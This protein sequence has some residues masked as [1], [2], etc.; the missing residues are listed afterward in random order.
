MA[1]LAAQLDGQMG[2]EGRRAPPEIQRY[3]DDASGSAIH[4]FGVFRG[5]QLQVH[6]TEDVFPRDSVEGLDK[7]YT[8]QAGGIERALPGFDEL[9]T[10]IAV[11]I[12]LQHVAPEIGRA[13]CRERV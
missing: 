11:D 1:A 6:S 13:S 3:V 12:Q 10:A 8:G 2:A 4:Q 9:P 7:R 5:R